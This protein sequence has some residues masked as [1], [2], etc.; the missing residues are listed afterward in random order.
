[1]L[2]FQSALT[3]II[4]LVKDYLINIFAKFGWNLFSDSREDD[5]NVKKLTD[6]DGR[7]V[8]KE[9][10][11]GLRARWAKTDTCM[12]DFWRNN[13]NKN[14]ELWMEKNCGRARFRS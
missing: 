3:K 1:M 14:W 10:D 5:E 9:A 2:N 13:H 8:M 11:M 7:K 12:F 6:D 4:H